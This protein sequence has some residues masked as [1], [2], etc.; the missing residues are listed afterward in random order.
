MQSSGMVVRVVVASACIIVASGIAIGTIE[1]PGVDIL[2]LALA[3]VSTIALEILGNPVSL[4]GAV[5]ATNGLVVVVAQQCTAIEL[6]LVFSAAVLICPVS[7]KARAFALLL[8]IPALCVLNLFRIISLVLIGIG[9]PQHLD[10]AHLV[11]WQIAMVVAAFTMWLF[12]LRWAYNV[13]R[14]DR[15]AA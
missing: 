2:A 13:R 12:W 3:G 11:V 10:L 5:I 1:L 6:L 8:G 9:F 15:L 7:L 14:N 4:D